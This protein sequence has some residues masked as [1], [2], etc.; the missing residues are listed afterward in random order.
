MT[1]PA[2]PVPARGPGTSPVGLFSASI[3]A[4]AVFTP[5]FTSTVTAPRMKG[6]VLA[7]C[8]RSGSK[9]PQTAWIPDF[10]QRF[11]RWRLVNWGGLS[12]SRRVFSSLPRPAKSHRESA[13]RLLAGLHHVDPAG[14]EVGSPPKP[15]GRSPSPLC[16][17]LNLHRPQ[18]ARRSC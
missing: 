4:A 1:C 5:G 15:R 13:G 9:F 14:G 6:G 12:T 11:D 3:F 18:P 7:V 8:V 2:S 10:S 17:V 16:W